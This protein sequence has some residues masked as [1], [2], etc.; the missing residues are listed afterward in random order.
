MGASGSIIAILVASAVRV[1]NMEMHLLLLGRIKLKWIAIAT[2]VISFFGLTGENG[3]GEVAHLGGALAGYLFVFFERKGKDITSP[4]NR[5]IDF[6]VNL[7]RTRPKQ[8]TKVYHTQKMS[9]AEFNQR[10]AENEKIIDRILDKIKTSG[11]ESLTT[12]EKRRLF[13]QKK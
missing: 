10:K 11:Y 3:G 2:V 5:I 12:E 13:D 9:D 4:I 1:P 7:F 8:K 6:F